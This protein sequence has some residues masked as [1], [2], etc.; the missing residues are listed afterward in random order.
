LTIRLGLLLQYFYDTARTIWPNTV[1]E[2]LMNEQ[3]AYSDL[4]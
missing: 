1:T 2:W 4:L 3:E